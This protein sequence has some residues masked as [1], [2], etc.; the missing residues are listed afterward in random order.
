MKKVILNYD[1]T[2]GNIYDGNGNTILIGWYGLVPVE[3]TT[4][5]LDNLTRIRAMG[6]EISEMEKLKALGLI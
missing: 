2:T 4:E 5:V 1:E 3:E 6:F